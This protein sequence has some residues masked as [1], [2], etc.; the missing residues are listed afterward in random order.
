MYVQYVHSGPHIC[1]CPG[2]GRH[3]PVSKVNLDTNSTQ[4][5]NKFWILKKCSLGDWNAVFQRLP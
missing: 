2:G 1:S 5:E 4:P 3:S